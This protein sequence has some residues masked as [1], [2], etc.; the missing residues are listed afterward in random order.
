MNQLPPS[1]N[2]SHLK[3]QAKSLLRDARAGDAPALQRFLDA[4]PAARGA[5]LVAIAT[6]PLALHDAHSVLAREYGFRS[7]AELRRY[8]EWTRASGAERV[9]QW[10]RAVYDGGP[11]M[12][13][14]AVR[15]LND[16][17]ALLHGDTWVACAVGDTK[18]IVRAIADDASWANTA[19]GPLRMPP[20]IA[21]THSSLIAEPALEPQLLDAAALLLGAGAKVN[22]SWFDARWPDQ[23]QTPIYGASGRTHNVA[24]TTLLLEAGADPNDNE[25]LYHSVESRDSA[26]MRLLLD[27]GVRVSGT[28]ALAHVLDYDKLHDLQLLLAHGGDVNERPLVHHAILRGRSIEHIR[29]LLDAGADI[30]KENEHGVSLF[31]FAQ[32]LGRT[33]VV[34]LLRAAGVDEQ[35]SEE[36][37]FVAVCARGDERAARSIQSR[38]PNVLN[39]LSLAQLQA[40]PELAGNGNLA[41]VRTMMAVGWPVDVKVDWDATALNKAVFVGDSAM[42]ELLLENG[43]DWRARHGFGDNVLGTLSWAS[44]AEEIDSQS[45]RDFVGCAR[46]LLAHGVPAPNGEEYAFSTDVTAIFDGWRAAHSAAR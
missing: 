27:A 9:E 30:R 28:N 41:A 45:L 34:E 23:P 16:E 8:V 15:L 43:A 10:L 46:A 22:G 1:P 20:L 35:L 33:D 11:R 7:W 31:R 2:L 13:G 6:R 21:V 24:M 42:A 25:S 32:A 44:L 5:D 38:T 26:C 40:L 29:M 19:G 18:A 37:E 12:R 17:P 14:M 4:L 3:R 39:R 36:D